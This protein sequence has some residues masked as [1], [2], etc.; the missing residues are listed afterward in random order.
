MIP[1]FSIQDMINGGNVNYLA[2]VNFLR[3]NEQT[4]GCFIT[5]PQLGEDSRSSIAAVRFYASCYFFALSENSIFF[6]PNVK[7]LGWKL[8]HPKLGWLGPTGQSD[9]KCL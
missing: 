4:V 5:H 9:S 8:K 1:I 2:I 7:C 6:Y 3:Q